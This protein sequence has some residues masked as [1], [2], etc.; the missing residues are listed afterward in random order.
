MEKHSMG[1]L[2][3]SFLV[4]SVFLGVSCLECY[5]FIRFIEV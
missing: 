1:V 4:R 2:S 3:R 5:L